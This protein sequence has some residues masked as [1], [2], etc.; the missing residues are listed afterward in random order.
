MYYDDPINKNQNNKVFDNVVYRT[1]SQDIYSS[2]NKRQNQK[3]EEVLTDEEKELRSKRFFEKFDSKSEQIMREKQLAKANEPKKPEPVNNKID[4]DYKLKLNSLFDA[5]TEEDYNEEDTYSINQTLDNGDDYE[6]E[7]LEQ[8]EYTF[9]YNDEDEDSTENIFVEK[10]SDYT[11]KVYT[12]EKVKDPTI[13]YLQVNKAKFAFGLTMLIF[14]LIQTTIMLLVFKSNNLLM[15]N[16][17]WVFQ[18]SY[19]IIGIVALIYCV[20][21]FI[22]PNKQSSTNFKLNYSLMFGSLSFFIIVILT[23]AI[24]TF[25]GMELFNISYYLATLVV[26]IAISLN[27]IFGPLIYWL[28]TQNKKFY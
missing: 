2:I 25:L 13:K 15:S 7:S 11:V 5:M 9:N 28:I 8:E 1:N 10:D 18:L 21:V 4:Y 3:N 14:M 22:S 6:D 23:Y 27:F 19:I 20:P 24:N 16:Q 12:E 17:F 26:P